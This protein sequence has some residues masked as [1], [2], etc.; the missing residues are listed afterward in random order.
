MRSRNH[1]ITL[2]I[3]ELKELPVERFPNACGTLLRALIELS[4]KTYLEHNTDIKDATTIEFTPAI[5]KA[6]NHMVSQ[7]NMTGGEAKAIKKETEEG[8]ARQ[9]FNGYMH[10]T[11]SYPSPIVIKGIFQSYYKFLLNCLY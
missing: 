5:S 10:D 7:G 8:G 2:I 3:Q 1:R 9:L 6:A 11:E 4:A